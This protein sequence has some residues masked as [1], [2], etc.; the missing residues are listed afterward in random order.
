MLA[1]VAVVDTEGAMTRIAVALAVGLLFGLEREHSNAVQ[2]RQA[3]GM[4]TFAFFGLAG[5]VAAA[6]DPLVVAG[7]AVAV[8]LLVAVSYQRTNEADPGLTTEVA[9]LGTYLLG[10]LA[11]HQPLPA[12]AAAVAA[13]ALLA[14]KEQLH[15]FV[16]DVITE[17]EI[18]DALKFFVVAVVVLPLLP[19]RQLGP[20]DALNPSRIWFVVVAVTGVGWVGYIATRALGAD[21]GLAVAGFAGGFVSATATTGILGRRARESP[22]HARAA[23]SGAVLASTA[24]LVQLAVLTAVFNAGLLARL[25]PALAA[26]T[27]VLLGEAVLLARPGAATATTGPPVGEHTT[28][29]GGRAFALGPALVLAALLS[30]VLLAARWAEATFGAAGV[31]ATSA[32]AGLADAHAAV[33]S[34]AVAAAAGQLSLDTAVLGTAL[35]LLTNTALKCVF[36]VGGGGL[37]FGWRFLAAISAPALVFATALALW[38]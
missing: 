3:L 2:G 16:R 13:V 17:D 29:L 32:L 10:A 8:G 27:V 4:R 7:G 36:A 21:R 31:L 6:V 24:T 26:T 38:S 1:A 22:R 12:V 9:G 33:L 20:Y 30:A 37:S 5:V 25:W 15:H 19:D 34:L 11:W 28:L 14:S 35:A 23:L 18:N